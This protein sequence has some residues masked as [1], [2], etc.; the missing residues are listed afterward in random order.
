LRDRQG[1][2]IF[3]AQWGYLRRTWNTSG[4]SEHRLC[5]SRSFPWAYHDAF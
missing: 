2:V 4:D 5:L 1:E 3:F